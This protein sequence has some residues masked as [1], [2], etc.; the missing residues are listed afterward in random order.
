MELR[1]VSSSRCYA[2]LHLAVSGA[3]GTVFKVSYNM[4]VI[5]CHHFKP[6]DMRCGSDQGCEGD[7]GRICA[8]MFDV[9]DG[10]GLFAAFLLLCTEV[11]VVCAVGSRVHTPGERI[12]LGL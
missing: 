4:R 7:V 2:D 10:G 5:R 11:D 8:G 3:S 12:L 1:G 9:K 6:A